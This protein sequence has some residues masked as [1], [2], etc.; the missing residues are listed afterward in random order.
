MFKCP[1]YSLEVGRDGN[2]QYS[3]QRNVAVEGAQVF[4]A[5]P[6]QIPAFFKTVDPHRPSGEL[7]LTKP[8]DCEEFWTDQSGLEIIWQVDGEPTDKITWYAGCDAEKYRKMGEDLFSAY[9]RFDQAV[10][11]IDIAPVAAAE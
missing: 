6:E 1:E 3:G 4:Q 8:E 5:S 9:K 2:V 10:V 11:L 7:S